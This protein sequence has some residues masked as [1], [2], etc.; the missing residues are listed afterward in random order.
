MKHGK[1]FLLSPVAIALL[2]AWG[3]RHRR[4]SRLLPLAAPQ[5][6]R[7]RHPAWSNRRAATSSSR[8]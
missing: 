2:A 6:F 1:P 4:N 5:H 3:D 7:Q 8:W